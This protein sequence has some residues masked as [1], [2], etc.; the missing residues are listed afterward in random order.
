MSILHY[1]RNHPSAQDDVSGIA[2]SR[3]HDDKQT[4]EKAL[5]SLVA[6][7]EVEV[8]NNICRMKHK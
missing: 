4:V 8:K 1:L 5:Q 7:G 3:V 2:Q 6:N